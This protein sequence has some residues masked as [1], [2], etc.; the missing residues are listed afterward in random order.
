VTR[1]TRGG[2]PRGAPHDELGGDQIEGRRA[3]LE[4]LRARRRRVHAVWLAAESERSQLL[5]EIAA[6]AAE[7][8][9]AVRTVDRPR[10]TNMA[11]TDAPQGVIARAEPLPL[12]SDDDLFATRA[13]FVVALDGVTD[14]RNVGAVLRSAEAAGATGVLLPKH[15]SAHITPAATKA[16]AGAVEHLPIALV[17]GIPS[18]LARAKRAGLWVVGL[19]GEAPESLFGL[20]VAAEPIV[21]VLG[22]E[23]RGLA[24]LTRERCDVLVR[25]PMH[26]ALDSLNVAAAAALACY[27]VALRRGGE[28]STRG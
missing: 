5:D 15:R 25:I 19:D 3:V 10:L 7:Q 23:G 28:T 2:R 6:L 12:A 26:G 16:A 8:R 11:R 17:P 4:A 21:L 13:A 9:V 14:P 1:A 18:A 24:R 20:T 27:E 22:A